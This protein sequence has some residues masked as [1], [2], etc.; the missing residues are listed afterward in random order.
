MQKN[1]YIVE[2]ENAKLK[3]W[4]IGNNFMT[5]E[6]FDELT[7]MDIV[8]FRGKFEVNYT[9]YDIISIICNCTKPYRY[10]IYVYN[11][12]S[13]N[14]TSYNKYYD[15]DRSDFN[16]SYLVRENITKYKQYSIGPII[17]IS[18]QSYNI[19]D[20]KY[21]VSNGVRLTIDK[22]IIDHEYFLSMMSDE[23]SFM[24]FKNWMDIHTYI[25]V[26]VFNN[27]HKTF[28]HYCENIDKCEYL[29]QHNADPNIQDIYGQ[30]ALH[31]TMS[32]R[33]AN[34]RYNKIVLLLQYGTDI[35]IM[36][37]INN[38]NILLSPKCTNKIFKLFIDYGGI[39]NIKDIK[40]LS[41][42]K[43]IYL[44]LYR[45]SYMKIYENINTVSRQLYNAHKWYINFR[46]EQ[47]DVLFNIYKYGNHTIFSNRILLPYIIE[48]I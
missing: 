43:Y 7:T 45:F 36:N 10:N 11:I 30:T 34:I 39:I 4:I 26:N 33:Y 19:I 46:N 40:N 28:L 25:N 48:F 35:Y 3:K 37:N 22:Y 16:N 15:I 27:Y 2:D 1:P 8:Y 6:K 41:C 42:E 18:F 31:C 38:L 21:I 24:R 44:L 5:T 20:N 23:V 29:L 12:H 14:C 17:S 32:S 47:N 13:Y 9:R